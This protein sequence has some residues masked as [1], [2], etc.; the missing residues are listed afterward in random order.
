MDLPPSEASS[1]APS[2]VRARP[3][4]PPGAFVGR[5]AVLRLIREALVE[6]RARLLTIL[7]PGG[8]GKTHLALMATHD[9]AG[10]FRDGV[11]FL[12]FIQHTPDTVWQAIAR[13]LGVTNASH[14]PWPDAVRD[15][16]REQDLLLIL[17]NCETVVEGFVEL[18]ALLA[19]CPGVV[20]LATSQVA[21][22]LRGEHELWLEPLAL[23][24]GGSTWTAETV[25]RVAAIEL[26]SLRAANVNPRFTVT[27]DTADT[28][29]AIV[30][31]LDGLPLAI[32]LAAAQ[33]RHLTPSA[34]LN[35][36]TSALPSL[37]GGP[38]DLPARHQSLMNAVQWSLGLLGPAERT[39]YLQLAVFADGFTPDA[40]QAVAGEAVAHD[41]WELLMGFADKSLLKRVAGDDDQP[42]FMMLETVRAVA[43]D[44]LRQEPALAQ[45]TRERHARFLIALAR[46]ADHAMHG[47]EQLRWL[48]RLDTEHANIRAVMEGGLVDE[49]DVRLALELAGPMFW[50]WYSRGWHMWAL[51]L[52][53][54]LLDRAP[55]DLDPTI[56]GAARTTAGW[57]AFKQTQVDRAEM[58]FAEAMRLLPEPDSRV[59]LL[60]RIGTAY[61]LSF[62]RRDTPGAIARLRTVV[63]QAPAVTGAW[64]E[65]AAG[66][67]GIGLLEYFDHH[68]GE[69]RAGFDASVRIARAHDDRQSLSMNLVYLAQ[70]DSAAGQ[71]L[72]ALAKLQEALPLLVEVGDRATI[73][74]ALDAAVAT[75]VALD[76]PALALQTVAVADRLRRTAGLP[77]SP[78]EQQDIDAPLAAI[79]ARPDH[80]PATP[81]PAVRLDEA[82][83]LLVRFQPPA[84][85]GA[86]EPDTTTEAPVRLA[87]E[88]LS[89]R[90]LEVLELVAS[91]MTA[92]EIAATLYVSP[93]TV[94]RHMANIR[95]KLGVRS[96]AAAVAALRQAD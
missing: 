10:Q 36:L 62:D 73:A 32:E 71:P 58:H 31:A 72:A 18:P 88:V 81:P 69:A 41:G 63:E 77:R 26:F 94:K 15:A 83:D 50:Y 17:D 7:G 76:E 8:V 48:R 85:G 56:R 54:R 4:M 95:R 37:G 75:L 34:L 42:R 33:M 84:M 22:R 19:A 20:V 29:A 39:A 91:G 11:C 51:P 52:I 23:P 35:R 67:F 59:A 68:A 86:E 70:L 24:D 14:A 2:R 25:R 43:L 3:G 57:L 89:A 1:N 87:T 9:I 93:H 60:A 61:V 46:E 74:L 90:E 92:A 53:E 16:L 5:D 6:R 27:D 30:R 96:Q 44:L 21:L 28:L 66:H 55:A 82:V 40:A 65:H 64:H 38:R 80:D 12:S 13:E 49:P 79:R 78:L 45:A 47:P